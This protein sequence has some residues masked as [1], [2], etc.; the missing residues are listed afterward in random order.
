MAPELQEKSNSRYVILCAGI[1]CILGDFK[2]DKEEKKNAKEIN[3]PKAIPSVD[4]VDTTN[5]SKITNDLNNVSDL[6]SN[7]KP[8]NPYDYPEDF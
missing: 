3:K 7:K 4:K 5:E 6:E 2:Y 8:A 1:L